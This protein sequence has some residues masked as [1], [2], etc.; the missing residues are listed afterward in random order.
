MSHELRFPA[1]P[2]TAWGPSDVYGRRAGSPWLL[3]RAI[4]FLAEVLG[5]V[6]IRPLSL[7]T[8]RPERQ[9]IDFEGPHGSYVGRLFRPAGGGRR[10]GVVL[11][12]GAALTGPDDPRVERLA[13]SL[14]RSGF[15][16]LL[17]WSTAMQDGM[18]QPADLDMLLAAFEHLSARPDVDPIRT[19]FVSFCV[20]ASYTLLAAASPEIANRV[21]FVTAFGPYYWGRDWLRAVATNHAFS[22]GYSRRWRVA[23]EKHPDSRRQYERLLLDGLMDEAES[24]RVADAIRRSATEPTGLSPA[25]SAVY[26]LLSGAPFEG[27]EALIE[28]LPSRLLARFD[29][30]SPCGQLDGLRAETLVIHST[31][32]ELIPVEESRRLVEALRTRVPTTYCE[33]TMFEHTNVAT[34]TR[35]GTIARECARL[36]VDAQ[37]LLGYAGGVRRGWGR[38]GG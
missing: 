31:G 37:V 23:W 16:T 36:A 11:F 25:A 12:L 38:Q 19:G 26:R 8:R 2:P 4:L 3:A 28:Q 1:S 34:T 21:A 32:D 7:L 20:G 33:L 14:A 17:C 6:P 10:A 24:E 15:V 27:V 18:I 9:E 29:R 30:V 22:D 35:I 13:A 5:L